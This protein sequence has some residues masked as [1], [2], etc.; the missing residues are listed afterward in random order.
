MTVIIRVST[1]SSVIRV[2]MI[3]IPAVV[4]ADETAWVDHH[5]SVYGI[6]PS[7]FHDW[8]L[9]AEASSNVSYPELII[10]PSSI[11]TNYA[12]WRL[13][14]LAKVIQGRRLSK[15]QV[16]R[17]C[18]LLMLLMILLLILLVLHQIEVCC[19]QLCK[20]HARQP[21]HMQW[22]TSHS[23]YKNS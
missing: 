5:I 15:G 20:I 14:I 9:V 12:L 11:I 21:R 23:A 16:V 22:G 3:S 17:L 18:T 19:I 1:L 10:A 7:K 8:R 13:N 2:V 4:S 6:L